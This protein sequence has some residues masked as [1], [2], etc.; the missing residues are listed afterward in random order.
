MSEAESHALD[1]RDPRQAGVY[2]VMAA[3]VAALVDIACAEDVA[4]HE[5]DVGAASD[6]AALIERIHQAL[7][8]PDDWGR[9]WDAL[10]DG[11]RDLSWLDGGEAPRLLI[12]RGLEAVHASA[13]D[14]D[15][16]LC[17]ILEEASAFWA[18]QGIALWSL[19]RLDRYAD[20]PESE[21]ASG[22]I[23]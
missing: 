8:F 19:V 6:K 3:D 9:N 7:A 13:P 5:I 17:E 2:R 4:V 16:T 22:S 14:L 15:A 10:S 18:E 21:P 11:L 23:H 12:W 1:L 20:A